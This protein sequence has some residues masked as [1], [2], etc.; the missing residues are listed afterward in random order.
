MGVG[1]QSYGEGIVGFSPYLPSVLPAV[2]E[3]G[4]CSLAA[5]S[6]GMLGPTE[7][8][9]T[10]NSP[11]LIQERG[12]RGI[13]TMKLI[14]D[15]LTFECI[16]M[17][18]SHD[19]GPMKCCSLLGPHLPAFSTTDSFT[20]ECSLGS[21]LRATKRKGLSF[22]SCRLNLVTIYVPD[23]CHAGWAGPKGKGECCQ[24][25]V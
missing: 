24:R 16:H 22:A 4:R 21:N 23:S 10:G 7:K 20:I 18:G 13:R 6:S 8:L 5:T 15:G 3:G 11:W 25:L 9:L 2:L 1:L 12:V 14:R 17:S 19:G